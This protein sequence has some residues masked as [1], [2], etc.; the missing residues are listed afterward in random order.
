MFISAW[1]YDHEKLGEFM[2]KSY[3]SAVMKICCTSMPATHRDF[4]VF[5]LITEV[6]LC[7]QVHVKSHERS[8]CI[9]RLNM[10]YKNGVFP[11]LRIPIKTII[12]RL[13]DMMRLTPAA[14]KFAPRD[15]MPWKCVAYNIEDNEEN[16]V[17]C[18]DMEFKGQQHGEKDIIVK[19]AH[20]SVDCRVITII[21]EKIQSFNAV[22]VTIEPHMIVKAVVKLTDKYEF[23]LDISVNMFF[24]EPWSNLGKRVTFFIEAD[25]SM[26]IFEKHANIWQWKIP[27]KAAKPVVEKNNSIK[28]RKLNN[29][30]PDAMSTISSNNMSAWK[31]QIEDHNDRKL[32]SHLRRQRANSLAET[33][34][35]K[36]GR[37]KKEKVPIQQPVENFEPKIKKV[38]KVAL[39][40][41]RFGA[42]KF[43]EPSSLDR[44]LTEQNKLFDEINNESPT[45]TLNKAANSVL[46]VGGSKIFL[47]PQSTIQND[48][49]KKLPKKRVK[50]RKLADPSQSPLESSTEEDFVSDGSE[51]LPAYKKRTKGTKKLAKMDVERPR[52]STKKTLKVRDSTTKMQRTKIRHFKSSSED[53]ELGIVR[54]PSKVEKTP[55]L[56]KKAEDKISHKEA[57]PEV[58]EQSRRSGASKSR[59]SFPKPDLPPVDSL[60]GPS[61][62]SGPDAPVISNPRIGLR[63]QIEKEKVENQDEE[64]EKMDTSQLFDGLAWIYLCGISKR[65]SK[66]EEPAATYSLPE[67]FKDPNALSN[68]LSVRLAKRKKK[69]EAL[70]NNTIKS[71]CPTFA[72]PDEIKLT[73]VFS[74][75]ECDQI[76]SVLEDLLKLVEVGVTVPPPR[77]PSTSSESESDSDSDPDQR[78]ERDTGIASGDTESL[79]IMDVMKRFMT[80]LNS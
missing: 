39:P 10:L 72:K 70:L 11:T 27:K 67:A 77:S 22:Q 31:Q 37:P 49:P 73:K 28:T 60:P 29:R 71:A 47:V 8:E 1:Q 56:H 45:I 69:A 41:R 14:M 6:T 40:P 46:N 51:Y 54:K 19:N 61:S 79:D 78:K 55:V 75:E 2:S 35:E 53:E 25:Q 13:F 42:A 23:T 3:L 74:F 65:S 34:K 57:E 68:A 7:E 43:K 21:P 50:S 30:S 12:A 63:K 33:P 26:E 64:I 66:K 15:P 20:I 58:T 76:I 38:E 59:R 52:S 17:K 80:T 4:T 44:T 16:L 36:R 62:E 5:H 48:A 9:S 24:D 18:C 32:Q